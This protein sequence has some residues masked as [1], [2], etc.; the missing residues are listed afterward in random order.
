MDNL[1]KVTIQQP[2]QQEYAKIYR[3]QRRQ[4]KYEKMKKYR[5]LAKDPNHVKSIYGN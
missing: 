2:L 3:D 4:K 5:E 1:L